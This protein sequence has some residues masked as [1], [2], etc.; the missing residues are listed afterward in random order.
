MNVLVKANLRGKRVPASVGIMKRLH[1]DVARLD[2]P[3]AETEDEYIVVGINEDLDE[4]M[5][6][7]IREAISFLVH[8]MGLDPGDT[9]RLCSVAVDFN[10][11]QVVN[12]NQGVHGVIPKSIFSDGG[13]IDLDKLGIEF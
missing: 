12:G 4:T 1:K 7:T 11:T 9:Y 5:S 10:V 8:Q 13:K 6:H 2:W 3:I